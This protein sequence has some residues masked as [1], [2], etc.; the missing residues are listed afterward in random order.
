VNTPRGGALK[1]SSAIYL[2]LYASNV[3]AAAQWPM[4]GWTGQPVA[5][6]VSVFS[7][8]N[9]LQ[10]TRRGGLGLLRTNKTDPGKID[11]AA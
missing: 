5:L 10:K 9:G 4:A 8:G 6:I 2:S 3:K 11:S 7:A 1:A